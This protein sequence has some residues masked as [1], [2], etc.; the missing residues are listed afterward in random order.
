MVA[1]WR[2]RAPDAAR[3][4]ERGDGRARVASRGGRRRGVHDARAR[5]RPQAAESAE[6]RRDGAVSWSDHWF[7]RGQRRRRHA[8]SA[9]SCSAPCWPRSSSRSRCPASSA[10]ST[11]ARRGRRSR[12]P[13]PSSSSCSRC[14]RCRRSRPAAARSSSRRSSCRRRSAG[15]STLPSEIAIDKIPDLPFPDVRDGAGTSATTSARSSAARRPVVTRGARRP[16]QRGRMS[17]STPRRDHPRDAGA[18]TTSRS[19]V[20]SSIVEFLDESGWAQGPQPR[21]ERVEPDRQHGR[22]RL[23]RC[24]RGSRRGRSSSSPELVTVR[25]VFYPRSC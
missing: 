20:T 23:G 8:S 7:G 21:A 6:R 16:P 13:S 12:F 17:T 14:R 10:R 22:A 4:R 11:T 3:P 19:T 25:G 15:C 18:P 5:P 24:G 2:G 9:R 1:Y